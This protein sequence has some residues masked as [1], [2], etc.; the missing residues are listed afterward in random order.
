M[1]IIDLL[2]KNGCRS[3]II[4]LKI[5]LPLIFLFILYSCNFKFPTWSNFV[6]FILFLETV[7][8]V[9]LLVK[10]GC[11]S[12]ILDSQNISPFDWISG[13]LEG[14]KCGLK[15]IS[16]KDEL[17]SYPENYL[18]VLESIYSIISQSHKQRVSYFC[19]N[20]WRKSEPDEDLK[21]ET[22][23][24]HREPPVFSYVRPNNMYTCCKDLSYSPDSL[25]GYGSSEWVRRATANWIRGCMETKHDWK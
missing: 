24:L 22:C 5:L 15:I 13:L 17:I 16:Q 25:F 12:D 10:N 1:K 19:L 2:V 21:S 23:K 18:H 8:I 3:D 9:D 11:R 6:L 4:A 14:A 20:C 7:K